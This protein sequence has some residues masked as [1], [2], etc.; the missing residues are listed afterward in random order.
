MRLEAARGEAVGVTKQEKTM[1]N[2][3]PKWGWYNGLFLFEYAGALK[4]RNHKILMI[5]MRI[6]NRYI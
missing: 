1:R 3:I 6:S 2:E 5:S 4:L